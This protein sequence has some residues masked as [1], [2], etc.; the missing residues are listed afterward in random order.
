MEVNERRERFDRLRGHA[1][2][3]YEMHDGFTDFIAG[4]S[5][6]VKDLWNKAGCIARDANKLYNSQPNQ[7][8]HLLNVSGCANEME[9]Q[10]FSLVCL[11][12]GLKGMLSDMRETSE[13]IDQEAALASKVFDKQEQSS[14]SVRE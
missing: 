14:R 5:Y 13:V 8:D 7:P 12:D 1:T 3:L 4:V 6:I 2:E 9:T 11:L 10:L